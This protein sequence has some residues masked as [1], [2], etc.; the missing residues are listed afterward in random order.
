[1]SL[2]LDLLTRLDA[3]DPGK[4][5]FHVAPCKKGHVWCDDSSLALGVAVKMGDQIVEDA[6]WLRKRD[7]SSHINVAE[8]DAVVKGMSLALK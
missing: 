7:D 2:M 1:M 5:M 4:G 6:A 3:E 8:L